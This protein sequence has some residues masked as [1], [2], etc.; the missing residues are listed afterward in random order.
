MRKGK[1]KTRWS[2]KHGRCKKGKSKGN[3][4]LV[5]DG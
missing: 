5:L 3:K 1:C 2:A 4:A